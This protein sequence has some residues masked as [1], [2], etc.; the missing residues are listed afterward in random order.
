MVSTSHLHSP[1][2]P[3]N[4]SKLTD[5]GQRPHTSV[6]KINDRGSGL[7][8]YVNRVIKQIQ[9]NAGLAGEYQ[10]VKCRKLPPNQAVFSPP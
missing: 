3:M 4:L 5:L 9:G 2:A 8:V 7:C 10:W 6:A 1:V